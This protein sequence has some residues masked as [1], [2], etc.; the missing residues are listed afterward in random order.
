MSLLSRVQALGGWGV[1]DPPSISV[2]MDAR[3][4]AAGRFQAG[5]FRGLR[6]Y[7]KGSDSGVTQ[8]AVG[9]DFQNIY[10]AD[11]NATSA[12]TVSVPDAADFSQINN[13]FDSSD[14]G[15]LYGN[16][17]ANAAAAFLTNFTIPQNRAWCFR[18]MLTN[19]HENQARQIVTWAW[20][21][22]YLEIF[23]GTVKLLRTTPLWTAAKQTTL[24]NL[25]NV[26]GEIPEADQDS[27]AALEAEIFD[28]GYQDSI[29]VESRKTDYGTWFEIS[30]IPEPRGILN[31]ISSRSES[32]V[33]RTDITQTRTAG[34]LWP[35]THLVL[36]TNGGA[37]FWQ[38]GKPYFNRSG[39]FKDAPFRWSYVNPIG[40]PS[41]QGQAD[42][43]SPGTSY[44]L[45]LDEIP[46]TI[47]YQFRAELESDGN[48]TPWIY[49]A[50]AFSVGGDR[51][52]S[53]SVSW[54]S[55]DVSDF[56]AN[57]EPIM[58][59]TPQYERENLRR[60]ATVLMRNVNGLLNFPGTEEQ[61]LHDKLCNV[62]IAGSPFITRGVIRAVQMG[63]MASAAYNV[64]QAESTHPWTT[65]L[66]EIC[67]QWQIMDDDA[68][69][70]C[71]KG[72]GL[73]LGA[74]IRRIL[75]GAGVK[76]SEMT[77][78]SAT[79][80]RVLPTAAPGEDFL[81][82]PSNQVSRGDYLRS[83]V[84][85]WGMG[86][87][88]FISASGIWTLGYAD[89]TI[90]AA[91]SSAADEATYR[92]LDP[93]DIV[94]DFSETYNWF[95]VEGAEVNGR[96]L[97]QTWLVQESLNVP[98]WKGYMGRIKRFPT[99]QNE[100]LRTAD[101]VAWV[102]RSR[103][104]NHA[105]PG[106]FYNF[107]TNFH[108]HLLPG[109]YITADGVIAQIERIDGGSVKFGQDRMGIVAREVIGVGA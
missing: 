5:G 78:V 23:D 37:M 34:V 42:M 97:R 71:P 35:A 90:Q 96:R 65:A 99:I 76:N 94:R 69:M 39:E 43:S 30:F 8:S 4:I 54:D 75:K 12:W 3:S 24:D 47:F 106:R 89:E 109:H 48:Y 21:R 49:A 105:K 70:D 62:T 36:S 93:L 108:K 22:W 53:S 33:E 68:M 102:L 88:L 6:L 25:R 63:N 86:M 72:D 7:R 84:L 19:S 51:T 17:D 16:G 1:P 44:E 79:A 85:D 32:F 11:L 38:I 95:C 60:N 15:L 18:I 77:G 81:I 98:D 28:P 59:I 46:D 50:E 14:P 103:V 27:I 45:F 100:G 64:T 57:G 40:T 73:Y 67:D 61:Y 13:A 29:S 55:N 66:F 80:G 2:N 56:A 82:Q 58:E 83:V 41:F 31:I 92:I 107:Q 101:E 26:E 52:G 20:E 74:Y 91:F 104:R 87:I 10:P 9:L